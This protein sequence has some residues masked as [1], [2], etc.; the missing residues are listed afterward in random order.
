MK[1][2]PEEVEKPFRLSLLE[3]A[4]PALGTS[5]DSLSVGV[6]FRFSICQCEYLASGCAYWYSHNNYGDNRNH[7]SAS[8]GFHVGKKA[9]MFGGLTLIGVAVWILSGHL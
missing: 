5:I 1:P 9:E 6:G 8:H 4:L 7:A 2:G 3:V